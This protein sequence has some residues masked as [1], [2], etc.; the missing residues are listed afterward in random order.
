LKYLKNWGI[1]VTVPILSDKI[2]LMTYPANPLII[3][4]T[5]NE[6]DNIEHLI[7]SILSVNERIHVLIV[8]DASPD[9]TA[10]AVRRLSESS[11]F[12]RLF[13]ISRP[14]KLGLGNAYV[15][16]FCW[17]LANHYDFLI[18]MDADWSHPPEYLPAMLAL[19]EKTDFVIGSRYING[20]GTLNWGV[21]R[22]MLSRFGSL[23]SRSIL[24][25]SFR[26]FTGG[27]NGWSADLLHKVGLGTL[28]SNGYGFQIELKYRAHKLG[29]R[30]IE[31]PIT[32][33][34]RRAGTSKMSAAIALEAFWRV[35][36]IR[37][38]NPKPET[39]NASSLAE[40]IALLNTA[41]SG[42][43]EET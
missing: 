3:I 10:G 8:D 37:L 2:V 43:S 29:F 5:Y 42:K 18:Q 28:R 38:S 30:H 27:F 19:A 31:F 9:D 17:G 21:G 12:E 23:Y 7:P 24:R 36:Q 1:S 40:Q 34:E 25:A 20:G 14:G 22:R 6:R 13:L 41:A 39:G 11:C 4:P 16:G 33:D 35:W 32:F 15:H 26:D